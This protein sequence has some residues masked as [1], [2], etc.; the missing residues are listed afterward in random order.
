MRLSRRENASSAYVPIK[1]DGSRGGMVFQA[2]HRHPEATIFWHLDE[3]YVTATHG[4]H[5]VVV[6]PSP[7]R[8][9]LTLVD[10]RGEVLEREFTILAK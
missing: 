3:K 2:T 7:G 8:H 4:I 9:V 6:A 1:L 5:Q 10:V